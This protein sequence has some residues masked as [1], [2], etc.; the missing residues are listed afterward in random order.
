MYFRF[1]MTVVII[2]TGA[3]VY[4]CVCDQKLAEMQ[5]VARADVRDMV[6][7][8]ERVGVR[9]AIR[10]I[11]PRSQAPRPLHLVPGVEGRHLLVP[12]HTVRAALL[13]RA[14]AQHPPGVQHELGLPQPRS[15]RGAAL[16]PPKLEIQGCRAGSES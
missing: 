15:N 6:R 7:D 4:M 5:D 14:A 10:I 16:R 11:P 13:L 9:H 8:G 12:V 1:Q 2:D 3:D